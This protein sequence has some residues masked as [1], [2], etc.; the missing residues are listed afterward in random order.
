MKY[1]QNCAKGAVPRNLVK[2]HLR[3]GKT[4][5]KKVQ[6]VLQHCCKTSGK[7]VLC[8]LPRM[9]K[10]VNN[11]ICC[12]TG[13]VWVVKRATSPFNSFRSNFARQVALSL[14]PVLPYL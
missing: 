2:F 13:L 10:P 6:I 1:S 11:L 9:F 3:F 14:L 7:A 5:N 12:K 8:V 4:G